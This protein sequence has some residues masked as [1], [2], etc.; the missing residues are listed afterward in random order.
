[1][2]P[3]GEQTGKLIKKM[4]LNRR[5]NYNCQYEREERSAG[6]LGY[7]RARFVDVYSHGPGKFITDRR[8]SKLVDPLGGSISGAQEGGLNFF[9]P[10]IDETPQHG[11]GILGDDT[12]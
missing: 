2:W 7:E 9:S 8:A 5:R 10:G 6:R 1:M 3:T 4:G 12:H 11:R